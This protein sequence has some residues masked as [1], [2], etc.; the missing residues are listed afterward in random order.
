MKSLTLLVSSMIALIVILL[1]LVIL[2]SIA[3]NR[4][5]PTNSESVQSSKKYA[6]ATA[7]VSSLSLVFAIGILIATGAL[8]FLTGGTDPDILVTETAYT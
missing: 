4:A 2:S 7:V 8:S 3:A 6:I 1:I 5:D